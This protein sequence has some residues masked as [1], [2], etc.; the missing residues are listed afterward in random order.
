M[1]GGDHRRSAT[2][3]PRATRPTTPYVTPGRAMSW[4]TQKTGTT[5]KS[6][7]DSTLKTVLNMLSCLEK[8]KNPDA[9]GSTSLDTN[10]ELKDVFKLENLK[11]MTNCAKS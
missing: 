1:L 10:K 5:G 11:A 9:V 7:N 8:S 3:N 2:P 6:S 4:G